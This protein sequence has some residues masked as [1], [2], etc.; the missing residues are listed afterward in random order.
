MISEQEIMTLADN[1]EAQSD[2][3]AS[4]RQRIAGLRAT[5]DALRE[6]LAAA[7][8]AVQ[9]EALES[10]GSLGR[11]ADERKLRTEQ[12]LRSNSRV[13]QLR[14]QM[15]EI[16]ADLTEAEAQLHAA[17]DKLSAMRNVAR[18]YSAFLAYAAS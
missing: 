18:L 6:E 4:L 3:C 8:L 15:Q 11:N 17:L 2:T 7:E 1:L 16:E 14:K 9:I 5:R 12:L 13:V 10:N